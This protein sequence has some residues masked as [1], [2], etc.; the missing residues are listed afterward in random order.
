M[1]EVIYINGFYY[2][3]SKSGTYHRN[4]FATEAAA[5]RYLKSLLEIWDRSKNQVLADLRAFVGSTN[6]C[7]LMQSR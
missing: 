3:Q 2:I 6:D 5:Q 1:V 7:K 4:K